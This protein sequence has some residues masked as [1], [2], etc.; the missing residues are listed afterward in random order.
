MSKHMSIEDRKTISSMIVEGQSLNNIAKQIE[1]SPTSVSRE[2]QHHRAKWEK[3]PYGRIARA[4]EKKSVKTNMKR[5]V[6]CDRIE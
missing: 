1:K 3:K 5:R 2:I 4:C 6:F